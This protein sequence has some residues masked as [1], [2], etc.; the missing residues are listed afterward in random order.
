PAIPD[1]LRQAAAVA[2]APDSLHAV[3]HSHRTAHAASIELLV[4]NPLARGARSGA[5]LADLKEIAVMEEQFPLLAREKSPPSPAR[6]RQGTVAGSSGI[7]CVEEVGVKKSRSVLG[8]LRPPEPLLQLV[9][10]S[11]L[12][13][14]VELG[15]GDR[16]IDDK[17]SRCVRGLI[18]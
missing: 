16:P 8:G 15:V 10:V 6:I 4:Q 3:A 11:S 1:S 18:L 12:L 9:R 2:P 14:C 7:S 13:K 5:I 17:E